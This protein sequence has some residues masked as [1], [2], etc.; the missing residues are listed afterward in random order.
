M[1][2]YEYRIRD[3]FKRIA[4]YAENVRKKFA[5]EATAEDLFGEAENLAAL[6]DNLKSMLPKEIRS[7][8]GIERHIG[9]MKI[10]LR[11]GSP[12]KC[13]A[14]IEDICNC[15]IPALETGFR[16]W[17]KS[18]AHYDFELAENTTELIVRHELDSAV[19]KAFVILTARLCSTFEVSDN[20]DGPALVNQVFGKKA[21]RLAAVLE[22]YGCQSTRD[23]LAGMYGVFRNKYAHR[24]E[25]TEWFEA[26]A[27]LT[28]INFALKDIDRIASLANAAPES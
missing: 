15:D 20:V 21:G 16:E 23:L 17:C 27:V 22:E 28:M 26:E 10:R 9:W 13:Y 25:E 6:W 3:E 18:K 4:D 7:K 1:L 2:L 19:R 24:D 8:S 11:D 5:A 14:D 12:Q